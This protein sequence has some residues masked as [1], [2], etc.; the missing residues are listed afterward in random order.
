MPPLVFLTRFPSLSY[1]KVTS[2]AVAAI[3]FKRRPSPQVSAIP[4]STVGLPPAS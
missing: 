2:P 3:L 1:A 4:R